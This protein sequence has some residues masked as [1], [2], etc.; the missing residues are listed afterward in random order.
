MLR[1]R[2]QPLGGP[3]VP[4]KTN[5]GLCP[6][7]GVEHSSSVHHPIPRR[8][9]ATMLA[10][11]EPTSTNPAATSQLSI[12]KATPIVPYCS[13]ELLIECGRY[14]ADARLKQVIPIAA[15]TALGTSANQP[16]R[17][18]SSTYGV[19]SQPRAPS[20]R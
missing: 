13:A 20:S 7:V 12:A 15:D 1:C 17:L 10:A 3:G 9:R 18:P 16:I 19:I 14:T 11:T 2:V 8:S 4:Q 6:P 5:T